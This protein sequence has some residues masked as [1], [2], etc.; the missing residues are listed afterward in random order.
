VYHEQ[1]GLGSDPVAL[2]A[3]RLLGCYAVEAPTAFEPRIAQLL[4]SLLAAHGGIGGPPAGARFLMPFLSAEVVC[5]DD[6]SREDARDPNSSTLG[7]LQ[8]PEVCQAVCTYVTRLAEELKEGGSGNA[9]D[10]AE[11]ESSLADAAIVLRYSL[12]RRLDLTRGG[13]VAPEIPAAV[14]ALCAWCGSVA[15][16]PPR[17]EAAMEDLSESTAAMQLSGDSGGSATGAEHVSAAL[18][19]G[20]VAATALLGLGRGDPGGH[21]TSQDSAAA[22]QAVLDACGVCCPVTSWGGAGTP[23]QLAMADEA[24]L[25]TTGDMLDA[26]LALAASCAE[27]CADLFLHAAQRHPWA[28]AAAQALQG[29]QPGGGPPL[30][31]AYT[32]SLQAILRRLNQV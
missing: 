20:C 6:G 12:A 32:S 31:P 23:P 8:G 5:A 24:L 11:M 17:G 25:P 4:P 22:C 15:R 27:S 3:I 13:H 14:R 16:P 18:S 19:A 9:E 7:A 2:A 1:G 26:L 29:Q 21:W 10:T 28:R 30:P